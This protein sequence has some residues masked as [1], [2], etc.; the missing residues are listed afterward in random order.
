MQFI[1]QYGLIILL[2]VLLVFMFWSSRRRQQRQKAEQEAKAKQTL[3]GAEVMLQGG[4]Y[5]TIVEYDAENLDQPAI[6]EIAPGVDIKVHSQAILR[7]VT[8]TEAPGAH[9]AIDD[10]SVADAPHVETPEET[11]ERLKGENDSDQK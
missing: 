11:A 9:E 8:P 1:Q 7:V 5:G 10:E 4:L 2:A 6:V 3:P